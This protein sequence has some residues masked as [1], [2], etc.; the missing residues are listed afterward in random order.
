MEPD[1]E[2]IILSPICAHVM[3][4]RSFVLSP[5]RTV[6]IRTEKLHSRKAYLSVD[7]NW[8]MDLENGDELIVTKSPE[9]TVMANMGLRSFY[10]I[11]YDKLTH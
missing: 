4:M 10:E 3:G 9:Y 5:D 2:N 11:A 6:V 7:G 8:A 1:A